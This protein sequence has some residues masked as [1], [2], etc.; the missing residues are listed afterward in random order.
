MAAPDRFIGDI[1]ASVD[2]SPK[3]LNEKMNRRQGAA[4]ESSLITLDRL[5]S[6]D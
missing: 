4:F 3:H 2:L 6:P 5:L 1:K